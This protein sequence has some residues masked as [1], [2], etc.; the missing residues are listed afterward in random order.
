MGQISLR[1]YFRAAKSYK[2]NPK[3]KKKKNIHED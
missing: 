2:K 1:G 3:N